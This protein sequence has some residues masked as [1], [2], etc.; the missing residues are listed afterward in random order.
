MIKKKIPKKIYYEFY[1][2][3]YNIIHKIHYE[4]Y[5]TVTIRLTVPAS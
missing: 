2:K 1:N 3:S 4:F 5:G